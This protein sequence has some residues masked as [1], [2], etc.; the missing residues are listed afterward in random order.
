LAAARRLAE[1]TVAMTDQDAVRA[2]VR[3]HVESWFDGDAARME[4]ILHP[5]YS[6]LEQF[7]AQDLIEATANGGGRAE[8]ALDRQISIEISYLNGDTARAVC[9][10]HR[11]AEVLQLVRTPEGWKILNGIWQSR[12]SLGHPALSSAKASSEQLTCE[13]AQPWT[14]GRRP[15]HAWRPRRRRR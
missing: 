9:L 11:Y 5:S 6:A 7:T 8:D 2:T 15:G 12:A 4:R 3:D 10:S 14:S 13:S 1:R